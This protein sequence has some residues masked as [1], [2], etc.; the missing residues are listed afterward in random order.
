MSKG[1]SLEQFRNQL[2]GDAQK[3]CEAQEKTIKELTERLKNTEELSKDKDHL[4]AALQ[5]R[6]W[7]FTQGTMC[8]Y[9]DCRWTCA[10]YKG[11]E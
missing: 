1:I 3:R 10:R 9:C 4:I 6:C 5:N 11:R 8:H 2:E 7:V